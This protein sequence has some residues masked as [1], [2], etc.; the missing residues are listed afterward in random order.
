MHESPCSPLTAAPGPNASEFAAMGK[1]SY[2][3][4]GGGSQAIVSLPRHIDVSNARQIREELL[5]AIN[6]GATALI[7][8]MTATVSCDHAG[9]DAV[10]RAYQNAAVHGAQLRL[11]VIAQSVQRELTLNGLDQLIPVYPSL[12]AAIA[13]GALAAAVQDP[14]QTTHKQHWA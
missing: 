7:A 14:S 5:S 1:D 12:D 6:H 11:V 8:D 3:M 4:R 10:A 2:H 9:V 13:A